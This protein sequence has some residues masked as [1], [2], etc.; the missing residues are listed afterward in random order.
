MSPPAPPVLHPTPLSLQLRR[1]IRPVRA[2]APLVAPR[3]RPRRTGAGPPT[4]HGSASA[5]RQITRSVPTCW[6]AL[7]SS[8]FAV[9]PD[10]RH[11]PPLERSLLAAIQPCALAA[12]SQALRL[13]VVPHF[14]PLCQHSCSLLC[15]CLDCS[16]LFAALCLWR[17]EGPA[18]RQARALQQQANCAP[19]EAA[20]PAPLGALAAAGAARCCVAFLVCA[21]PRLRLNLHSTLPALFPQS[22]SSHPQPLFMGFC[23]LSPSRRIAISSCSQAPPSLRQCAAARTCM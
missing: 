21:T 22:F 13:P 23:L 9:R 10:A 18:E 2:A 16:P 20:A 5:P 6:C 3:E 14:W 19:H 11:H 4:P 12:R 7:L 1:S 15:F 8:R 17:K